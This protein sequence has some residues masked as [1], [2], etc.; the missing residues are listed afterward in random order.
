[1]PLI[2]FPNVPK[3]PGVPQLLRSAVNTVAPAVG[4]AGVALGR[5]ALAFTS[6]IQWG[7]F[8]DD[9]TPQIDVATT[10]PID[11]RARQQTRV[12]VLMP[13]SIIDFGYRTDYQVSTFPVQQGQFA[14]Y[15]KVASPFEISLR[16]TKGGSKA[17]REQFLS[18]IEA[19][20]FTTA[21]YTVLTPEKEYTSVN[22]TRFELYRRGVTGAF[23]FAE[24]DL[25]AIEIREVIPSYTSQSAATA[26]S[27][28]DAA[29][30]VENQGQLQTE[31]PANTTTFDVAGSLGVSSP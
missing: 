21:L 4:L 23:F 30:P 14:S 2:P 24:V 31:T 10:N 12:P 27:S 22:F 19:L 7:I 18:D 26:N 1:M 20:I 17:D 28:V 6:Q 15:N 25:F 29:L 5:L 8:A 13:D 11:P 9:Q 3:L 16:L